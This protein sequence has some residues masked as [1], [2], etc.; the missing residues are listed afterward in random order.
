[1]DE[2]ENGQVALDRIAGTHYDLV[3]MDMQMPVL[4]G[5]TATRRL[6]Q[7]GNQLPVVALTANAMKGF[8]Q[9]LLAAG[10]TAYLTKPIDID[11]LLE[12]IA[13]ILGAEQIMSKTLKISGEMPL[14]GLEGGAAPLS[15]VVSR[16]ADHPRLRAVV[17]RFALQLAQRMQEFERTRETRNYQEL[18]R[19]AHWLKGAAGTVGFDVF[20]E[21]A[22]T[23][24][25]AAKDGNEDLVAQTMGTLRDLVSRVAVPDER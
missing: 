14:S 9:E 10:C 1:V 16:L 8:E 5:F 23:L 21:P 24:E 2:A 20:T 18:A 11:R 7:E 6:R 4:D 22:R 3:L 13:H 15:P 19:L 17:R 12:C 25:Q